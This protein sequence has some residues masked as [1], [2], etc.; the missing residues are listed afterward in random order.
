MPGPIPSALCLILITILS[1][2]KPLARFYI[3]ENQATEELSNL[4][5]VTQLGRSRRDW[6]DLRTRILWPD[7][8]LLS[9]SKSLWLLS[10][11]SIEGDKKAK[12][13]G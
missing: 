8:Y 2:R 4:L 10:G 9:N 1:G 5:K 11:K 3:E 7:Y 6:R 12:N 13:Y